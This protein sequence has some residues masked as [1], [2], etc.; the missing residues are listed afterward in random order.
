MHCIALFGLWGL[1]CIALFGLW[2]M[3]CIALF[4][5]WGM[6]CI[7]HRSYGLCTALACLVYG[8]CTALPCLVYGVCTALPCLVY[9]V[10]TALRCLVYGVCTALPCLVYGVCTA[11]PIGAMGSRRGVVALDSVTGELMWVHSEREGARGGAA[12]RQ[13]SGRGL[14]YWT[15]GKGNARILYVTP[16]YKL[17]SL[18]ARN[19]Q[20]SGGFGSDGMVDL[21]AD[22]DQ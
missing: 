8:V 1:H 5:L 16:G 3:H 4:G 21:K 14:S 20:R 18:N 9:G 12:P 19:G 7:A 22:F 13:L 6:H 10:C 2:S 11:L 17:V 15:D